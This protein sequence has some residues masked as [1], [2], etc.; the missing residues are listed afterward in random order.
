MPGKNTHIHTHI[1]YLSLQ[2]NHEKGTFSDD[3]T[4]VDCGRISD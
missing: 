2:K 4:E 1:F 3:E